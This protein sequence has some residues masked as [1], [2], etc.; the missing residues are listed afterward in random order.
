MVRSRSAVSIAVLIA[1]AAA[2]LVAVA[3]QNQGR[4]GEE[5]SIKLLAAAAEPHGRLAIGDLEIDV[6][7]TTQSYG[8][9]NTG[10]LA[11]GGGAGAG[12]AVFDPIVVKKSIDKTSPVLMRSV[13]T[14]THHPI[15]LVTVYKPGTTTPLVVYELKDVIISGLVQAGSKASAE[16]VTLTFT[17]ITMTAGGESTCFDIAMSANC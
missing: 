13:A 9:V 1:L 6:P 4:S 10:T 14:G 15:A 2:I 8:V 16:E 5:R 3:G 17:A 7:I 11:S 12:K